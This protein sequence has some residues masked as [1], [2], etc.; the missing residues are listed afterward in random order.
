MKTFQQ[1]K[2]FPKNLCHI[3]QF[4]CVENFAFLAKLILQKEVRKMQNFMKRNVPEIHE[5][6]QNFALINFAKNNHVYCEIFHFLKKN[7]KRLSPISL[8]TLV[9]CL[10]NIKN[11]SSIS[12]SWIGQL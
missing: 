4:F 8:E 1:R 6:L 2:I 5:N 3:L 7:E 11:I 12:E 10:E 9:M